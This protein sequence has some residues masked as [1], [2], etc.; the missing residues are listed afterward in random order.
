MNELENKLN[1]RL[2]ATLFENDGLPNILFE[3]VDLK[4]NP[5][6]PYPIVREFSGNENAYRIAEVLT[7]RNESS[8]FMWWEVDYV[9]SPIRIYRMKGG[10]ISDKIKLILK[11]IFYPLKYKF[12]SIKIVGPDKHNRE[13]ILALI[14]GGEQKIFSFYGYRGTGDG[15]IT[16][17]ECSWYLYLSYGKTFHTYLFMDQDEY[18]RL[19]GT[20]PT[21]DKEVLFHQNRSMIIKSMFDEESIEWGITK[22]DNLLRIAK[23]IS[24]IAYI[25][26]TFR[27]RS[28]ALSNE[29]FD[30]Y[31]FESEPRLLYDIAQA[32]LELLPKKTGLLAGM[33]L[34]GIPVAIILSQITNIPALFIRKKAKEYGTCKL[35]EGG[36]VKGRNVV[37]IE[38]VITSGGQVLKAARALREQGA[39]VTNVICVIDREE[40]GVENLA[41]EGFKLH[42]LL[43]KTELKQALNQY[44]ESKM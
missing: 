30:K 20:W 43:T 6:V 21:M 4:A 27:L 40:G 37:I 18:D 14:K 1:T 38:D 5:G 9:I 16:N 28:G 12:D 2:A 8:L 23:K 35:V 7:S 44:N 34:G 15:F 26:G 10:S 36:E 11:Q 42:S 17:S 31:L 3:K 13:S 39:N 24:Q 22:K 25:K 29:Y 41:S 33:E 19:K 32:M